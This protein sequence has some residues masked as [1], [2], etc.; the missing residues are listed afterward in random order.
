MIGS[1]RKHKKKKKNKNKT[2]AENHEKQWILLFGLIL[3]SKYE[4]RLGV[5]EWWER[6]IEIY[7]AYLSFLSYQNLSFYNIDGISLESHLS[8]TLC[9]SERGGAD[10]ILVSN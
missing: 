10:P 8:F 2:L 6:R 9:S 1:L 4:V 7:N 5:V 3:G